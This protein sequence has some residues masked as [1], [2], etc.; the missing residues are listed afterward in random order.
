MFRYGQK[1]VIRD[2]SGLDGAE[3]I[4]FRV[5]PEGIQVLLDREVFWIVAAHQLE[6]WTSGGASVG[7]GGGKECRM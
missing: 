6:H 7:E 3:G 1:V 5:N 4:V 2:G